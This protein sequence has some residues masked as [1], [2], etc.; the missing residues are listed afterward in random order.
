MHHRHISYLAW[1]KAHAL[2]FSLLL[3][4]LRDMKGGKGEKHMKT[5]NFGLSTGIFIY[6]KNM[7]IESHFPEWIAVMG[8]YVVLKI[9]ALA[10]ISMQ[11]TNLIYDLFNKN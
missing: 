6:A 3:P 4:E 10:S 8:I 11:Q 2:L 5:S 1:Q 9:G 7:K